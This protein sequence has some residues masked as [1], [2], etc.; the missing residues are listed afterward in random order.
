MTAGASTKKSVARRLVTQ[1]KS[2][3]NVSTNVKTQKA[4]AAPSTARPKAA[5]KAASNVNMKTHKPVAK[6]SVGPSK[7]ANDAAITREFRKA[8]LQKLDDWVARVPNPDQ[9]LIGSASGKVAPLS[10]R[11][12]VKHVRKRTPTGEKLVANWTSLVLK[13][14]KSTPLV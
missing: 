8:V 2:A 14:I 11:S 9:P 3:R 4:A 6:S 12:I 5:K 10:P 1:P 7:S 13:N